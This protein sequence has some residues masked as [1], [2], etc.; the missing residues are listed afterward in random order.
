M[1]PSAPTSIRSITRLDQTHSLLFKGKELTAPNA[2]EWD[3]LLKIISP[4]SSSKYWYSCRVRPFPPA[5][6]SCEWYSLEPWDCH[7]SFWPWGAIRIGKWHAG[8]GM[9]NLSPSALHSYHSPQPAWSPA[10]GF[11]NLCWSRL[12]TAGWLPS[13]HRDLA[14]S[15]VI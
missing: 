8:C 5:Y 12:S 13:A 7:Q 1:T 2:K 3:A 4:A 6:I 15:C 11:A 9:P 10:S 14:A